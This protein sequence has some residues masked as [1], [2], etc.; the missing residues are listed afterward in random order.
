MKPLI[1]VAEDTRT[2][3][4]SIAKLLE[5]EGFQVITAEDGQAAID[6][7]KTN[8]PDLIIADIMMPNV[9]G[10]GLYRHVH[11]DARL[12][13]IPFIFLTAKATKNDVRLGKEMGA[14]D[15]LVKPFDPKDLV[16]AVRGKLHRMEELRTQKETEMEDLSEHIFSYL[17]HKLRVPLSNMRAILNDLRD[18]ARNYAQDD[19]QS[20][21]NQLDQNTQDMDSLLEKF[22]LL[23]RLENFMDEDTFM[24]GAVVV[25]ISEIVQQLKQNWFPEVEF[26]TDDQ[27]HT[28]F[29]RGDGGYLYRV[30]NELLDNARRNQKHID[31]K[32]FLRVSYSN[33][34]L[35]F[36]V[37]DK[38]YGIPEKDLPRIFNKFYQCES[39]SRLTRGTGLGLALVKIILDLH[40][41]EIR[42]E[43]IVDK[44]SK[45]T[46]TLPRFIKP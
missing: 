36:E 19:L 7:L 15:Y 13:Q 46:I 34:N 10:Y 26:E 23:T 41:G 37:E 14:D 16:A 35:I 45:F 40:Q 27:L 25:S 32:I 21:Y 6:L 29:A 5:F 31:D 1:L 8:K 2:I 43:S 30:F 3:L 24:D 18:P 44:G 11:A 38:G 42:V 28:L 22:S 17:T 9:D 39:K 20:I 33:R 4:Y 12:K